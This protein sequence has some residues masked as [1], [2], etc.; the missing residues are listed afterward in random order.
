[1]ML[2]NGHYK[3]SLLLITPVAE[4]SQTLLPALS[5]FQV[6]QVTSTDEV[7]DF[8]RTQL[9]DAILAAPG[10]SSQKLFDGIKAEMPYPQRPLL[11]I[12]S[13]ESDLGEH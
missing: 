2:T 3:A 12:L 11:I 1:M 4:G 6:G 7:L 13:N 8:L 10:Y 5:E 9:P